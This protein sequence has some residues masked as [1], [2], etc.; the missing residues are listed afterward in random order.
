MK[1][2][3]VKVRGYKR[4][5]EQQCLDTRGRVVAV[6]GPNEAGKTS[7]LKAMEFLSRDDDLDA[8]ERTDRVEADD[9]WV[10]NAHYALDS[11]D[12]LALGDLLPANVAI[13]YQ[14]FKYPNGETTWS[15]N[16]S[17]PRNLAWRRRA[18]VGLKRMAKREA[19]D[20]DDDTPN[21]QPSLT[22]RC[23]SLGA[24]MDADGDYLPETILDQLVELMGDIQ[25]KTTD[26]PLG[27][28][29]DKL[30]H[31]L[32][33]AREVEETA[34]PGEQVNEILWERLPRFLLF[35]D[36]DRDL[37]TEYL[38]ADHKKPPAALANLLALA[39]VPYQSLRYA[40]RS[41]DRA[42]LDTLRDAADERLESAFR[43]WRQ[44]ELHV[45]LSLNQTSL[46]LQVRDRATAKRTR[47]DDRS[48]GLRRFA[49]LVAFTARHGG[50]ANVRP[51]LLIDEAETHLHYGAQADLV[52]VFERQ[53]AAET[54]IY[55]THSIGC[56]PTDLGASIR[57]VSPHPKTQSRSVIRNSVWAADGHAVGITPMM[58]AMGAT[59]LA[60][61]PARRAVIGEGPTEAILLPTLI[62]EAL[63]PSELE[64]GLGYQVVPG[65]SEVDP[66][67]AYG[68]EMEAG[69][70]AYLV[71]ND[72][73][74]RA[75]RR[76]L[77]KR[78][79]ED[80]RVILLGEGGPS[81]ESGDEASAGDGAAAA[82]EGLCT[83]DFVDAEILTQAVNTILSRQAKAAAT[84]LTA[85]ELPD[86]GRGAFIEKWGLREHGFRINKVGVAQEALDIG[87]DRGSLLERSR[88]AY[89]RS[90]HKALAK[91]TT[92]H[93]E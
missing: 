84:R 43:E 80:G 41:D 22:Q 88:K 67:D 36:D 93:G 91:A 44:A 49:A 86:A 76:K 23:E 48:D 73:G 51:V 52:R 82:N 74:G 72:E 68:L 20:A 1:L 40:A 61:T 19:L 60:F 63:P 65:V 17:L 13:T 92:T 62:R 5:G 15:I 53:Q 2:K 30:V 83:E 59:A 9:D 33:R 71:D 24:A 55:T 37:K 29:I 46:Q 70:V 31:V 12:R 8:S 25:N 56:L 21:D 38:W 79:K 35:G 54:I 3:L 11:D 16:P 64:N 85:S 34:A 26:G 66:D 69:A 45:T 6:I 14:V 87:R 75:H 39:D 18:S 90:L 57:V 10:V 28:A 81:V 77:S 27:A 42:T 58:L 7:L 50:N 47:L 32:V 4:F 78:A 89:L